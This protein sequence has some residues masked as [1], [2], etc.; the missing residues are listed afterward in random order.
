VTTE[1]SFNRAIAH[2]INR[3][4][5]EIRNKSFLARGFSSIED[6]LTSLDINWQGIPR[7]QKI[8]EGFDQER[9]LDEE[10]QGQD[11][12]ADEINDFV[13]LI[14]KQLIT[15]DAENAGK[16]VLSTIHKAKGLEFDYVF[17][18]AADEA[19]LPNETNRK[20]AY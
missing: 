8:I 7:F 4:R 13:S 18:I 20:E 11:L 3:I 5:K 6:F 2:I 15:K 14:C 10:K 19:I 16:L 17:L 12:S 9:I 1:D